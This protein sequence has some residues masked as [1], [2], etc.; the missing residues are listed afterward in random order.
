MKLSLPQKFQ[1]LLDAN[2]LFCRF[3]KKKSHLCMTKLRVLVLCFH[4][5]RDNCIVTWGCSGFFDVVFVWGL[6]DPTHKIL[7]TFPVG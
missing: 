2:V 7:V 4:Y 5:F 3:K 6:V 1:P